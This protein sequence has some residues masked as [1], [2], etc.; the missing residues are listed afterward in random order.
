MVVLSVRAEITVWVR[1]ETFFVTLPVGVVCPLLGDVAE[2]AEGSSG[3]TRTS[4][5]A[6]PGGEGE[7][8]PGR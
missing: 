4:M 7:K 3:A 5:P 8:V 6:L 2:V 1:D